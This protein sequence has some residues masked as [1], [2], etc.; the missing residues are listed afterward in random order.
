VRAGE[1]VELL[2]IDSS[3]ERAPTVLEFRAWRPLLGP[4][5]V[6]VF[7]DYGHPDW[8]G[9][10]EAVADLGLDGEVRGGLFVWRAPA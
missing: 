8:P 4:G 7:D 2:F 1:G 5:A 9:V 10:A 3:H 6:V